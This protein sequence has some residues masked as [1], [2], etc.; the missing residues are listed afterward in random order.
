ME[1]VPLEV[2]SKD[3]WDL[4]AAESDD[5]WFYQTTDWM[6][7]AE[8][9]NQKNFLSNLSFSIVCGAQKVAICPL[10]VEQGAQGRQFSFVGEP[11]PFPAIENTVGE[12]GRQ[13]I[14]E[15]Y[16]ET[17]SSLAMRNDVNYVSVKIPFPSKTYLEA[18]LLPSNPLLRFGYFDLPYLT[19]IIDLRRD[20]PRMWSG[21]RKGHKADIKRAMGQC[22]I[23][24]WDRTNVTTEKFMEYQALHHKDAGRVTRSQRTF[25][26]MRDWV[27][28]GRA[29]L[30]EAE[31]KEQ[32]IAFALLILYKKGAFY[33]SGCKDPDHIAL[34]AAHLIQWE[35]VR[36]LKEHG[37]HFYDVG[38]QRFK[39]QWFDVPTEKAIAISRFKRG[40]GG[41][42][43]PLLTAEYFYSHVV[44]EETFHRRV[45]EYLSARR[46]LEAH[47][48]GLERRELLS[49]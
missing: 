31:H 37:Y 41:A 36:W 25:D 45:R 6:E 32:P 26:L 29:V 4:F 48:E 22:R 10:M 17:L 12:D 3:E 13:K 7:W 19:Q 43:V 28:Q 30:I 18:P 2:D 15:F 27:R 20:E 16:T 33:G 24:F 23:L 8:E 47:H 46:S 38:M 14:L 21:V 49:L 1:A 35:S 44:L 5:A 39:P 34:P 9:W 11:I 42:T 40:F